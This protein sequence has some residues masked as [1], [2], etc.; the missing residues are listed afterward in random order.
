LEK[1]VIE[2]DYS[3]GPN[4]P[5]HWGEL[6]KEWK[7]CGQGSRQSPIDI[8]EDN[9]KLDGTV[10]APAKIYYHPAHALARG[11]GKTLE[12]EWAAGIF[13]CHD[14][15]YIL[16]KLVFHTPSEHTYSGER[17]PLEVQFYHTHPDQGVAVNSLLFREGA[18]NEWLDQFTSGFS[19]QNLGKTISLGLVTSAGVE[20]DDLDWMR[21]YR[22]LGSL[23][24]P[25][26][27]ER[28]SVVWSL[29]KAPLTASKEQLKKVSAALLNNPNSR[30]IQATNSRHVYYPR[31]A[32]N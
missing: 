14:Y 21:Y 28:P 3:E 17:F 19:S 25:P 16:E 29:L 24:I 7:K 1:P 8:A 15:D 9:I 12:V 32:D 20:G 18:H 2:W 4:G 6:S 27:T 22:Y 11:D 5:A 13:N 23:N 31:D 30:P 10:D 26:C